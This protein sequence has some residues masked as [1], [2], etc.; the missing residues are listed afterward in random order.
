MVDYNSGRWGSRSGERNYI[1]GLD[2]NDPDQRIYVEMARATEDLYR[3]IGSDVVGG[4]D[5]GRKLVDRKPISLFNFILSFGLIFVV[6]S[7]I[8]DDVVLGLP[9]GEEYFSFLIRSAAFGGGVGFL[10][11]LLGYVLKILGI[12]FNFIFKVIGIALFV[13]GIMYFANI[14]GVL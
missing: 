10:F 11:W 3:G 4:V 9:M 13:F 8:W 14:F 5:H 2:M 12:F 1:L 7:V 6:A